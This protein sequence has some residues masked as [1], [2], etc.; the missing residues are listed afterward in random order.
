MQFIIIPQPNPI[1][2]NVVDFH[3]DSLL[4]KNS[5]CILIFITRYYA[6]NARPLDITV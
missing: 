5:A 2:L 6:Q 4:H 1:V 3:D